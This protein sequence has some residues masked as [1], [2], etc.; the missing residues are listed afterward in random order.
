[1]RSKFF[2][3]SS[4]TFFS[5]AINA[6]TEDSIKLLK[7]FVD[8]GK[9]YQTPPVQ[10]N[11]TYQKKN[12]DFSIKKDS[13]SI[14]AKFIIQDDFNAYIDFGNMEQII[15]DS[16][17]VVIAK[18]VKRIIVYSGSKEQMRKKM[19]K[20]GFANYHDSAYKQL[21]ERYG[22]KKN[23][24]LDNIETIEL[25]SKQLVFNT[26]KPQEEISLSFNST[27]LEP[28]EMTT[29]KRS[30]KKI[31]EVDGVTN[32]DKK[33]H[34]LITIENKGSYWVY[35]EIE[36]FEFNSIQHQKNFELPYKISDRIIKT[37]FNEFKP[38]KGFE[39]FNITIH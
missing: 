3:L 9:I 28:I 16:I 7:Q 6:K 20:L 31:E 38:A 33:N 27:T 1:V 10:V 8:V 12:N 36:I 23:K 22:V 19:L 2:I 17:V 15:S 11:V 21:L 14:S 34:E 39:G 35:E 32:I 24:H 37:T 18:D 30:L 29:K 25:K 26:K 5:Y 13:S 4:I